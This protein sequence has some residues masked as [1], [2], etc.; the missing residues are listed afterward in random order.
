M[1]LSVMLLILSLII[2]SL[3]APSFAESVKK[4]ELKAAAK[5]SHGAFAPV[6]K[7]PPSVMP[8]DT[9][10]Q[11][12]LVLK[13]YDY[14]T[15]N[16]RGGEPMYIGEKLYKKGIYAHAPSD[17]QVFL[18]EKIVRVTADIGLY[19]KSGGGSVIFGI[20][21]SAG[22]LFGSPV[23]TQ[24]S[25]AM[26]V[27]VAMRGENSF[28]L[29]LD[30]TED[31]IAC[32]QSIWGDVRAYGESGKVYE[33]GDLSYIDKNEYL[34]RPVS[35]YPFSF[36]YNGLF[37]DSILGSWIYSETREKEKDGKIRTVEEWSDPD[38]GLVVRCERIDYTD[39]PV[40]EWT[41]YFKNTGTVNTGRINAV[42]ALDLE[43]PKKGK[44]HFV[45]HYSD[46]SPCTAFDYRPHTS[47]ITPEQRIRLRTEGG[48]GTNST[49]P[50]FDLETGGKGGVIA[51]L[52]WPGQWICDF[53]EKDGALRIAG[54]MEDCDFYLKPGE[55]LRSPLG[56]VMHYSGDWERAQNIWRRFM[57]AHN[58][59]KSAKPA[60]SGCSSHWFREMADANAA[61]Q[62]EFIRRYLE[63]GIPLDYW[64]MD[65]GWY[66]CYDKSPAGSNWPNTGTWEPDPARFPKGLREVSD[67]AH[68][69]GMKIVTWFEP[70]RVGD[71]DSFL[72]RRK[73]W[74]LGGAL[75]NLSDPQVVDWLIQHIG[76]TIEEQGIDLYRQDFN[77]DPLAFWRQNDERGRSGVT[78]IKYITGYLAFWDAL[79]ERFPGMLIDSCAS[80]GRRNDLETMRRSVPLHRSDYLHEP[81]GTQNHTY[82]INYWIPFDGHCASVTDLYQL[83]SICV[84]L[85][86]C[87]WDVRKG[88]KEYDPL[89][90]Q[91]LGGNAEQIKNSVVDYDLLRKFTSEQKNIVAPCLDG[92]YYALTPYGLGN[93][94]WTAFE[95][96]KPEE[97]RG[98]LLAFRRDDC[99][100][101]SVTVRLRDLKKDKTYLLTDVDTG[102]EWEKKGSS[103]MKGFEIIRQKGH[104]S[105]L[106]T[107][108]EKK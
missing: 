62:I 1:K 96:Y 72:G 64:W 17:L 9:E 50:Y 55:E 86:N 82:G 70:E 34:P 51:V 102:E 41:L 46:G 63:E 88:D 101:N 20:E 23:M 35:G 97:K 98:I 12:I 16:S 58:T 60:L 3:A 99:P 28:H 106:I 48:R 104:S 24:Q 29:T 90:L 73:E 25:G 6:G 81:V 108:E 31:G 49:M 19:A 22:P 7:M 78:E 105:C 76:D 30:P 74:L 56:L 38:S 54:G 77:I 21:D 89:T 42:K 2:L 52:G 14:T 103:L 80:G 67:Y 83:R 32:D 26:P 85:F 65:A 4:S 47:V 91:Y 27:D 87:L 45:L 5:W 100:R 13:N 68:S 33:L 8:A 75:L 36:Y 10:K 57:M 40:T 53:A 18:P 61:D 93:D 84:N 15:L 39:F 59:P 107:I 92:D 69:R 94:I 43:I 79:L 37:S 71:P 44:E 11:G 95:F 66:P